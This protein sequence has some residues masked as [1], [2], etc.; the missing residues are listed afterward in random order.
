MQALAT[1]SHASHR[2]LYPQC[3]AAVDATWQFQWFWFSVVTDGKSCTL[4]CAH[5]PHDVTRAGKGDA[6][7]GSQVPSL[8]EP[9]DTSC[10]CQDGSPWDHMAHHTHQA[11]RALEAQIHTSQPPGW[12]L[13]EPLI[14]LPV[15][16]K[17]RRGI[18]TAFGFAG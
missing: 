10:L 18:E 13:P 16:I 14:R 5:G 7:P 1:Q 9:M 8:E 6:K 11:L 3:S 17:V 15:V 12:A 2:G 4:S